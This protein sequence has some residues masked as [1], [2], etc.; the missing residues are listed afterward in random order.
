MRAMFARAWL[1]AALLLILPAAAAAQHCPPPPQ[2]YDDMAEAVAERINDH[3]I[4]RGLAP[5]M[6]DPCLDVIAQEHSDDMADGVLGFEHS[7]L[8]SAL[9]RL[10]MSWR[11]VGENIAW[12]E[13]SRDPVATALRQWL[14]SPQHRRTLEGDYLLTGIGVARGPHGRFYFTQIFIR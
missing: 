13:G 7:D 8:E 2:A 11:R 9:D 3:R 1:A 14:N 6:R 12:D 5:V 4:A 10:G